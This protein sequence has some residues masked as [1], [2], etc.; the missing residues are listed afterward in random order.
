M[1]EVNLLPGG[2]KRQAGGPKF[3]LSLPSIPALNKID[4]WIAAAVAVGV[5]GAA[6]LVWL[7]M[8]LGPR[9]EEIRL[10]EEKALADS[11]NYSD[12]I[13]RTN[14][15]LARKDSVALRVSVI[16]EIDQNRYVWPHIMDE[17]ARALPDFAWI[18]SV[19][20]LDSDSPDPQVHLVGRAGNYQAITVFM[21]QLEASPWIRNTT[22]KSSTQV[23]L[24]GQTLH[25]FD[26]EFDY[27]QPPLEYL[28][29]VPLLDAPADTAAAAAPASPR[30][31]R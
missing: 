8:G 16:Q 21:E 13:Q 9:E 23:I 25:S 31:G 4:R 24:E 15:L 10:A 26:L 5:G 18:E 22:F 14:A 19:G 28:E 6:F 20:V 1:I 11:A 2:K 12:L 30:P 29:T 7:F 27:E 3:G 17:V